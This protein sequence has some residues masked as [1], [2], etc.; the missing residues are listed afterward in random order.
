MLLPRRSLLRVIATMAV[1]LVSA[2]T[3]HSAEVIAQGFSPGNA[4]QVVVSTIGSAKKE[5]R[6]AAYS[7]T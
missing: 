1:A 7:F 2:L 5:L 3:A 6:V 4:E